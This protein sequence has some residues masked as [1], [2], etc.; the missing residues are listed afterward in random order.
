MTATVLHGQVAGSSAYSVL[1]IPTSA[2]TAALGMHILA[3]PN[4]SLGIAIDN[5]SLL[6]A[7]HHKQVEL[8]YVHLFDG[9][10]LAGIS[11]AYHLQRGGTL[12]LSLRHYNFGTFAGYD[13]YENTT[14]DFHAGD[15]AITAGWAL[16][17]DSNYTIGVDLKPVFSNYDGYFALLLAAD[18]AGSYVSDSRT[19]AASVM[20]RNIGT[21]LVSYDQTTERTPFELAAALSYKLSKAPFRFFLQLSNLQRW[22]L[23]YNDPLNP[24][25]HY[26]PYADT[27]YT[28]SRLSSAWDNLARHVA[29]GVE[30]S[31]NNV[32][33]LRLGYNHRQTKEQQAADRLNMNLSGFA[34]G[35]GI[36]TK[37]FEFS[38]ARNN[39]HLGQAPNYLSLRLQF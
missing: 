2:R 39:Y 36:R 34:Y 16:P 22:N 1:D 33:F 12:S 5:P 37:R 29:V 4:A 31:M 32:V 38:Y 35:I 11:G 20:A 21:Q 30:L 23:R 19:F 26:D 10:H 17:I 13:E 3:L 7:A 18:V 6:N 15:L 24:T 14:G 9:A 27:T 8:T 28:E 25:A